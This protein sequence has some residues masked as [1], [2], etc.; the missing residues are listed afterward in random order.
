[1]KFLYLSTSLPEEDFLA[2]NAK[3]KTKLNPAGQNFHQRL[4]A[5]LATVASVESFGL[6]PSKTAW[7]KAGKTEG[8]VT[9]HYLDR[10]AHPAL[11][12]LFLA[13][14]IAKR[15]AS[16]LE[17]EAR[18]IIVYDTLNPYLA[19]AARLLKTAHRIPTLAICSDD[20][21]NIT[22]VSQSYIDQV[23]ALSKE[24]SAYLCLT[25]ALNR[26]F[27]PN[28]CPCLYRPGVVESLPKTE[29]PHP[30]RPY[31]YYGGA[32]FEKDG[33]KA[34]LEAY[35][36]LKPDYDLVLAGHG[37]M[38]KE[39]LEAA[40]SV[41]GITF[42]GQIGKE[43]NY[44]YEAHAA[45]AINPRLYREALDA[46][47]VPS[48]VLEYLLL[49]P[50]IASTVSSPLQTLYPEGINWIEGDLLSFL[51]EHLDDAGHFVGLSENRAQENILSE[52][53]LE[54]TGKAILDFVSNL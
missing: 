19:K 46:V 34:L 47:S 12:K 28:G 33:T 30:S 48:K 26:K 25:E 29:N 36:T 17:K 16:I 22:G 6:L 50:C 4:I 54:A 49:S 23:F 40:D 7:K 14:K 5:S 35:S 53:G 45:L 8:N 32:L 27:N 10:L 44:A 39:C 31:I 3:R 11:D 51:K 15:I 43:M 38:E 21:S 2:L 20:P 9:Y 37:P 52:Y 41:Q 42:L 18:Y 13:K 24:A 1:M